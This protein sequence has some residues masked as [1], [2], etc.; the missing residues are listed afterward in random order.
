MVF[1][2]TKSTSTNPIKTLND[3]TLNI[4]NKNHKCVAYIDFV[5][6]FDSVCHNKLLLKL[7]AYGMWFTVKLDF[8]F[9]FI[10]SLLLN[11]NYW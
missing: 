10:W 5:K 1:F 9:F 8:K 11:K 4:K 6:A 7:S 2:S 3:C